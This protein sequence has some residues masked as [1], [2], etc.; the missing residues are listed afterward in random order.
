MREE[1]NRISGL[2]DSGRAEKV[3]VD[4]LTRRLAAQQDPGRVIDPVGWLL[5]RALPQRR[6]CGDL[7][8]DEGVRLD[9]GGSCETCE[10]LLADRR[11]LRQAIAAQVTSAQS[12]AA[13]AA[14]RSAYEH[15]L[16][17]AA[18]SEAR[19]TAARRDAAHAERSAREAALTRIRAE[20]ESAERMR[21]AA[22]CGDCGTP[23]SAGLCG[24]CDNRRAMESAIREAVDI[25][26]SAAT[27]PVDDTELDTA[28]RL[29]ESEIREKIALARAKARTGGATPETLALLG[30]M[31]AETEAL[32]HR[33]A[34]L[35]ALAHHDDAEA[36]AQQAYAAWM[37]GGR[38]QAEAGTTRA[39]AL[40]TSDQA[41]ER[42]AAYLLEK[43]LAT[44]RSRR[45][46]NVPEGALPGRYALGAER[47]RTALR[48]SA[49]VR[50]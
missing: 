34:A 48:S 12:A 13:A 33:R 1:L 49:A 44:V 23:E 6:E 32:K 40:E 27:V 41:R 30:R 22:P 16:R 8:C 47:A 45:A 29:A 17:D 36:E 31:V 25:S 18:A 2:T 9:S 14:W 20:A 7:R 50:R 28:T 10:L 37:R 42:T 3:L 43:R 39:A 26:I 24:T 21:R 5:G 11:S 4:R 46:R 38:P 15:R 35:S 19:E